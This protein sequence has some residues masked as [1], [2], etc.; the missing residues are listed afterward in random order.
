M[1]RPPP[2][3][4]MKSASGKHIVSFDSKREV[5]REWGLKGLFRQF[6]VP[7]GDCLVKRTSC[8]GMNNLLSVYVPHSS[9]EASHNTEEDN[10]LFSSVSHKLF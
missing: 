7:L 6:S 4:V 5:T 9:L 10:A 8:D 3:L 1:G 2:S